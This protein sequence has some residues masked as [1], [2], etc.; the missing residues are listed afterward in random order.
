MA[1]PRLFRV[2]L[3]VSDIHAAVEWYTAV[4]GVAGRRVG[5]NREYFD[6]GGT[7]LAARDITLDP[8]AEAFRPNP[9]HVYFSVTDLEAVHARVVAAGACEQTEIEQQPWGE[10]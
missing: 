5:P 8:A 7:I 1:A 6:C 9:D 2:I 3:P 10:R 4:L